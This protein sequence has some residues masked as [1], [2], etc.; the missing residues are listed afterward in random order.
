MLLQYRRTSYWLTGRN[1]ILDQSRGLRMM[2]AITVFNSRLGN[3]SIFVVALEIFVSCPIDE[4]S[5][6][7]YVTFQNLQ[8]S[9]KWPPPARTTLLW[10][11]AAEIVALPYRYF[12]CCIIDKR[13]FYLNVSSNVIPNCFNE[14]LYL[15]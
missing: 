5:S 9:C 1:K 6:A 13:P 7:P 11:L 10:K 8:L 3:N 12:Y 14:N 2:K 15:L 4:E